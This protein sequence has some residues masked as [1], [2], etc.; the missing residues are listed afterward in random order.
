MVHNNQDDR[1][2]HIDV[3]HSLIVVNIVVHI[4]VVPRPLHLLIHPRYNISGYIYVD[5]MSFFYYMLY[6][7]TIPCQVINV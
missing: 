6:H 5:H 4:H 1:S 2:D 7:N 3:H